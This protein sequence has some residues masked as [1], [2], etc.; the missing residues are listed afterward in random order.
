MKIK[1]IIGQ[2][3]NEGVTHSK[4]IKYEGLVGGTV[5]D[6]Y[7]LRD[8]NV[9]YVLKISDPRKIKAEATFLERYEGSILLPR[10]LFVEASNTYLVYSFLEGQ[11]NHA[12]SNKQA[13]LKIL[14]K[15]LLN[16]Y[17]AVSSSS[18]WGWINEPTDSWK[19]FLL[20]EVKESKKY[21][22]SRLDDSN[23][24]LVLDVISRMSNDRD[25]YLLHGDCG[26]HNFIF[27]SSQ[28]RGVID[29]DP[30]VGDPLYDLL[31]AFCSSPKDLTKEV[32]DSSVGP[33]KNKKNR[34]SSL[35]EEVLISLYIRLGRSVRHHPEDLETYLT[36]WAYWVRIVKG[37]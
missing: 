6:S 30:L 9:K 25:R 4:E 35:Y 20:S 22:S 26:V 31:Y 23:H 28:L 10:L 32:I 13:F 3:F 7:L 33:L 21:I 11:T 15:E 27:E 19:E 5:S 1:N 36:S 17:I 16:N 2:L 24:K 12:S 18:G 8:G 14:V 37:V 34:G 29:P